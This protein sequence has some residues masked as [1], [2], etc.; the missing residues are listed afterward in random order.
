MMQFRGTKPFAPWVGRDVHPTDLIRLCYFQVHQ[1]LGVDL[2]AYMT[3]ARPR[4][5]AD[6]VKA[7]V[8]DEGAAMTT[9][10][11]KSHVL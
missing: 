5:S 4:L 7:H 3:N 2:V 6:A 1:W 8:T 9:A 11:W 10:D